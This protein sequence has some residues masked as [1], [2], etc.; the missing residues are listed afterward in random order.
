[1]KNPFQESGFILITL[2]LM[3]FLVST[4]VLFLHF[5]IADQWELTGDIQSQLYSLALAENGIEYARTIL[6]HLEINSLLKGLDGDHSGMDQPEWRNPM[7]LA[8]ARFIDPST[9]TAS[10]DDG[11]P[12]AN[13]ELLLPQGYRAE[14]NGFFFLRA[15]NNPEEAADYDEDHVIL[16]RSMGIVPARTGD[17]LLPES[18]NA[19]ALVEAAFRQEVAFKLRS[20]LTLFADSGVFQWEGNLFLISGGE[21]AVNPYAI[22]VISVSQ[23]GLEQNVRDS[24]TP[25]QQRRIQGQGS[26]PS[27]EDKTSLYTSD[28]VLQVLFRATFWNHLLDQL[29]DFE[30]GP[31][32]GIAFFPGGGEFDQSFQGIL[33]AQG[34]FRLINQAQ[35]DGLLIHLGKGRLSLADQARVT[36]GVWMS[37]LDSSAGNLVSMPLQLSM[38]DSAAIIFSAA[39]IQQALGLLPPTQIGWRMLFP[40]MIL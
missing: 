5:Q 18:R 24:L 12:F 38:A 3:V 17:P 35:I 15:S 7:S 32:G 29:P 14:G 31:E 16:I 9:W 40:E 22:G 25:E 34:D 30:D 26:D 27:L 20:P 13:Q 21:D 39:A 28:A 36:G 19:V 4:S 1:M 33:V 10:I 6:P 8:E 23:S 2:I 37:N 11:I